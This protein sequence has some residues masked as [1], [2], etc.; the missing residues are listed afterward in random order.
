MQ[1]ITNMRKLLDSL[2]IEA[3][4]NIEAKSFDGK[5]PIDLCDLGS[6]ILR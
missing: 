2:A 1:L 6:T 4:A 5:M 3:N